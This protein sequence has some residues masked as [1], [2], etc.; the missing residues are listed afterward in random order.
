MATA[1]WLGGSAQRVF[2]LRKLSSVRLM[3]VSGLPEN[4]VAKGDPSSA[5]AA[6]QFSVTSQIL[7]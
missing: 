3:R 1:F 2:I 7:D 4:C 6:E 5:R